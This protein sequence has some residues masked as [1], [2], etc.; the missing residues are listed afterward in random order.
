MLRET[1][2]PRHLSTTMES[3]CIGREEKKFPQ[4]TIWA[5]E[6]KRSRGK[7]KPITII[8]MN[9]SVLR[10]S[11][12]RLPASGMVISMMLLGCSLRHLSNFLITSVI[13]VSSMM[14]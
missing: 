2:K 1:G 4:A 7:R 6:L 5:R 3:F 14:I 12:M 8:R 9:N 10:L 13:Q 11:Q